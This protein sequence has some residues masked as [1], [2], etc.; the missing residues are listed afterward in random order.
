MILSTQ[1]FIWIGPSLPFSLQT[2]TNPKAP[3]RELWDTILAGIRADRASFVRV[4]LPGVF[5][6]QEGGP[7]IT[8]APA[9]LERYERMIDQADAL[10]IERCVQIGTS[11]DFT[12]ELKRLD[13]DAHVPV[14]LLH[15]DSDQ[16]MPAEASAMI[17]KDIVGRT[18]LRIYEKAAHGLYLTHAERVMGDML[19]FLRSI[20]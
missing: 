14:L 9:V 7:G 15:G 1:G 12:E 2:P 6:A 10:A 11:K 16:G 20:V 13:G 4:S 18:D 19:G 17:V 5:G 3:S 8:I